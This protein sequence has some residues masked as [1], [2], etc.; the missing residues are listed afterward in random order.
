MAPGTQP[1]AVVTVG[2]KGM[3]RAA[4]PGPPRRPARGGQRRRP[5]QAE[6]ATSASLAQEL[7][8]SMTDENLRTDESLIGKLKRLLG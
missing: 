1:G 2:G 6:Q 5:A 3:P 7:A 8:D 4:P